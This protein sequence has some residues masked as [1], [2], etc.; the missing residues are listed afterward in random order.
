MAITLGDTTITGLGVGGL[1]NGVVNADDI[2]TGAITSAKMGYAGAVVKVSHYTWNT[3]TS[4][5]KTNASTIW[6]NTVNKIY[7]NGVSSLYA[8]LHIPGHGTY[9]DWC[10]IYSHITGSTSTDTDGSA[11]QGITYM[12]GDASNE[13]TIIHMNGK[14]FPSLA[15]GNH[16]LVIGWTTRNGSSGDAPAANSFNPNSGDDARQHQTGSTLIV[17]EILD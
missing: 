2:A 3:R 5:P 13:P 17:Y 9:S 15:A 4:T 14:K 7:G 16:N 10:G 8:W 6:T 1:P 12:S 11:F